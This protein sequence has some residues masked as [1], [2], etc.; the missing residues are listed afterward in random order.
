[1]PAPVFIF[2][3]LLAVCFSCA[4]LLNGWRQNWEGNRR[5]QESALAFLM[6]DS[7]RMFANHFLVKADVYFHSGYYPTIFDG[8]KPAER[9][10]MEEASSHVHGEHC[11]HGDEDEHE[12]DDH[13]DVGDFLGKPRDIIDRF[14]RNFYVTGHTHLTKMQEREVLPWL[15]LSASLDPQKVQTYTVASFWLRSK[16][17]KVKE[18]EQF[19]R[20]GL[21]HNPDSF[22]ILFE[23]GKIRQDHHKDVGG[24][25]NLWELAFDKWKKQAAA[26]V[27]PSEFNLQQIVAHLGD[28]EEKEGNYEAAIRYFEVLLEVT[29]SRES[30]AQRI[31]ELRAVSQVRK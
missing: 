11:D 18:A 27:N 4:T 30:V 22:E 26:G 19:L 17:G 23:L 12:E 21:R 31:E 7:R 13:D 6:G 10:H 24:A 1:M 25:R 28:L 8:Q 5:D 3:L 9:T 14:G 16:L 2:G 29:P 20:E 15:K